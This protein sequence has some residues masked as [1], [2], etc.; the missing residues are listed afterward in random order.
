M[1]NVRIPIVIPVHNRGNV[2]L[3]CLELLKSQ[4]L[5][6]KYEVIVVDDGS[7]DGTSEEVENHYPEVTLLHGDGELYWGGA[8]NKGTQHGLEQGAPAVFWLNDDC[9][10]FEGAIDRLVNY[11]LEKDVIATGRL[12]KNDAGDTQGA[13]IKGAMNLKFVPCEVGE[14]VKCDSLRGNCVCIPRKVFEKVGLLDKIFPMTSADLD[15]G[16]RCTK[17]GFEIHMIGDARFLETEQ[18]KEAARR[19]TDPET[20]M[21]KVWGSFLRPTSA[22]H[23]KSYFPYMTRH[24][25]P[26][27]LMWFCLPYARCAV[28]T[29]FKPLIVWYRQRNKS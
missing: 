23:Y 7:K 3:K 11:A 28:V 10:P 2:T 14:I 18:F 13:H 1:A 17:T 29:V 27:G 9:V 15:F 4:G 16:L 12:E 26:M 20:S 6:E 22:Y 5:M 25:G 19:W 21:R 24:W 8:I